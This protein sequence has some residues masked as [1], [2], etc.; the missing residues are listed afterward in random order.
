MLVLTRKLLER[1]FIGDDI[2]V[3]VVRIE[4]G[5]VRLGIEAPRD[6]SVIR[7]ELVAERH[8]PSPHP[9]HPAPPARESGGF[10]R[11]PSEVRGTGSRRRGRFR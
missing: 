9:A 5:Q 1:L 8:P 3:T 4:S 11:S 6:I 10:K 7:S 2:C